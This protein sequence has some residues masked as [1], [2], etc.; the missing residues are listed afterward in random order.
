[1]SDCK[2]T[3]TKIVQLTDIANL[4]F[5]ELTPA[6][7]QEIFQCI[8]D[9]GTPAQFDA[10]CAA[11]GLTLTVSTGPDGVIANAT[12]SEDLDL[13]AGE[14]LH[15][16]S[17]NNTI[18]FT[19]TDGSVIV[20]ADVNMDELTCLAPV[21]GAREPHTA[22]TQT[23]PEGTVVTVTN[24]T[25]GP[26]VYSSNVAGDIRTE[27]GGNYRLAFDRP[28]TILISPITDAALNNPRI[29]TYQSGTNIFPDRVVSNGLPIIYEAGSF[30]SMLSSGTNTIGGVLLQEL[31]AV[32]GNPDTFAQ[33]DWGLVTVPHT[34]EVSIRGRNS[35][36]YNITI[37]ELEQKPICELIASNTAAID[38][39]EERLN[40]IAHTSITNIDLRPTANANEYTVEITWEDEDGNSV[41][42]TD[43]TPLV[44][45]T[46]HPDAGYAQCGTIAGLNNGSAAAG[47]TGPVSD[48]AFT[49]TPHAD[50]DYRIDYSS[51][52]LAG[53]ATPTS[54][55]TITNTAT[56][57]VVY[58]TAPATGDA[59]GARLSP[60]R[61]ENF[62][63]VTLEGGVTYTVQRWAGGGTY[64]QG[65]VTS[66]AEVGLA[67]YL[68]KATPDVIATPSDWTN[69]TIPLNTNF[70]AESRVSYLYVQIPDSANEIDTSALNNGDEFEI[71]V[72]PQDNIGNVTLTVDTGIIQSQVEGGVNGANASIIANQGDIIRFRKINGGLAVTNRYPELNP[73]TGDHIDN[74]DPRNPVALTWI[75]EE[76]YNESTGVF[77]FDGDP[78]SEETS[79][80]TTG[81]G[82]VAP[83]TA[84]IRITNTFDEPIRITEFRI[85][86]GADGFT[87]TGGQVLGGVT[88]TADPATDIS[89]QDGTIRFSNP[90][91]LELA[92][93]E[94][95]PDTATTTSVLVGPFQGPVPVNLTAASGIFR[96]GNQ[97][98]MDVTFIIGI[99]QIAERTVRTYDDG[100]LFEVDTTTDTVT[101][102]SSIPATWAVCP[103]ECPALDWD[104]LERY[105]ETSRADRPELGDVGSLIGSESFNIAG[106][107][108]FE[109]R[110]LEFVGPGGLIIPC[111]LK[112]TNLSG[113]TGS[114]QYGNSSWGTSGNNT[115]HELEF[116]FPYPVG[117]VYHPSSLGSGEQLIFYPENPVVEYVQ[118][119]G[120]PALP[121][122]WPVA[123]AT[124]GVWANNN[125]AASSV[126]VTQTQT[127]HRVRKQGTT[128]AGGGFGF[129]IIHGP[130]LGGTCVRLKNLERVVDDLPT[131]SQTA[132]FVY[133]KTTTAVETVTIPAGFTNPIVVANAPNGDVRISN[134]TAT[135]FDIQVF[136][137]ASNPQASPTVQVQIQ[138]A[139]Q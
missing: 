15:F 40:E 126:L 9:E 113:G 49:F 21:T 5:S 128:A 118:G 37:I 41:T 82:A 89:G 55:M 104:N 33:S 11:L 6:Q 63:I 57:A 96:A 72:H 90:A 107:G 48:V 137:S 122:P 18:M 112:I 65:N 124:Q 123:P 67:E 120:A 28:V 46:P 135:S 43:P 22:A 134:V 121:L 133:D 71:R 87:G 12:S 61:P 66:I 35:G 27:G 50:G 29:W 56:G 17:P 78:Q 85:R 131:V 47:A 36:A 81:T 53:G 26:V 80:P 94:V 101:P 16:Y 60:A 88:F 86:F 97:P 38:E 10:F 44:I 69:D 93:G 111:R 20:G 64:A 30:D 105:F 129:G 139:T 76:C 4:D 110:D 73:V 114:I 109:E 25:S 91:G 103:P 92:A 51:E 100:S 84:P 14:T 130:S 2:K 45:A 58:V 136:D 32:A 19:V 34:T 108:N 117:L 62:V 54:G 31:I 132:A 106:A 138:E 59:D 68:A 70:T 52:S 102:L 1:M 116:T 24:D 74:T 115:D 42:T 79:D 125:N 95:L 13:C 119:P 3:K 7:C 77:D 23:L 98:V 75:K 127:V 39:L 99:E 8:V 83:I